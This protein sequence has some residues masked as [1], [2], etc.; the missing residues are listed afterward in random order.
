MSIGYVGNV[1]Y[2]NIPNIWIHQAKKSPWE[3]A[4][5]GPSLGD[6]ALEVFVKIVNHVRNL[7][8][9]EIRVIEINETE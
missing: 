5:Q 6:A 4:H 3:I 9:R 8:E 1:I 7:I 2:R